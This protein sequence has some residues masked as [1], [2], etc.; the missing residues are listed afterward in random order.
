[1]NNKIFFIFCGKAQLLK[2][3]KKKNETI[4]WTESNHRTNKNT[5][6]I[7]YLFMSRMNTQNNRK[8]N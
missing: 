1:M 7:L 4:V 2:G 6:S 3:L 5:L 8:K